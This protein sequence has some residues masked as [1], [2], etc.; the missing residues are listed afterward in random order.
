[1]AR[2][3]ELWLGFYADRK[4]SKFSNHFVVEIQRKLFVIF[5][6]KNLI[7]LGKLKMEFTFHTHQA[8]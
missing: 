8:N 4:L 5:L 7:K 2:Y 3:I 6:L 1:M